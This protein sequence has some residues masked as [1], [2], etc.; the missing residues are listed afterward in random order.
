MWQRSN[1]RKVKKDY[2]RK[3]LRNPFFHHRPEGKGRRLWRWLVPG[4]AVLVIGLIWFVLAAPFWRLAEIRISGLSRVPSSELEKI[5]WRQAANSRWLFF[6]QDN[7]FLFD[8]AS[9]TAAILADYNFSGVEINQA[10][11]RAL[12]IKVSERPYAFIFQEGNLLSYASADAYLIREPAVQEAD[13]KKYFI[14]EN[15][16][17]GT[18]L[19]P[20]DK[21]NIS[22]DYLDFIMDLHQ[23][24]TTYPE[25]PVERFIIDQELNTVKVKF[26]NGPQ[27]YFNVK[28]TAA[29]QIQ[30]LLL[31]KK[32]K[33][34]DNFSRTNYIDLRFGGRIFIYPDFK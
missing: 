32:E 17:P 20:K 22:R 4:G 6:K 29:K 33:I 23:N 7:I 30:L 3:N 5:V 18:L 16:N 27:V 26:A 31:V 1:F 25:L 34:K 13:R 10:W 24:L 11:P 21:I 2:Q 12:E 8:R 19:G 14:L 9:A 28:D 15:Q